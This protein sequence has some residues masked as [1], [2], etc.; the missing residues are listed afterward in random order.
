MRKQYE[1][2]DLVVA[3]GRFEVE[4]EN[5]GGRVK[6]SKRISFLPIVPNARP[7]PNVT[8]LSK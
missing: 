6:Y 1:S 5:T 2:F 8:P 4:F 3:R 7:H